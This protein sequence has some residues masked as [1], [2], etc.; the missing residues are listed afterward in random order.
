MQTKKFILNVILL[1]IMFF[2]V[3]NILIT[4]NV[5]A[6]E[7]L[8]E[9][10]TSGD[11][12][13]TDIYGSYYMGQTFTIGNTGSDAPC[14]IT[15]FKFKL[16]RVGSPTSCTLNIGAGATSLFIG[17]MYVDTTVT[18]STISTTASFYEFTFTGEWCILNSNYMY[19][20]WITVSGGDSSNYIEIYYDSASATYS[21]GKRF[22]WDGSSWLS[23]IG[24]D[25]VFYQYGK[26]PYSSSITFYDNYINCSGTHDNSYDMDTGFKIWNNITGFPINHWTT[27]IVNADLE[28]GWSTSNHDYT[29]FINT[30]GQISTI[31]KIENLL[32]TTGVHE[33]VYNSG[34][35]TFTIWANYS[36]YANI[37]TNL[38][39]TTGVHEIVCNEGIYT[40]WANYSSYANLIENILNAEGVHEIVCNNGIYTI[41]A[42]YTGEVGTGCT[43]PFYF[44]YTDEN[45]T[46]NVTVNGCED[47]DLTNSSVNST[48][49]LNLMSSLLFDDSQFITVILISLWLFM[50]DQDRKMKDKAYYGIL[51]FFVAIPLM[52]IFSVN[53]YLSSMSLGGLAFNVAIATTIFYVS[54]II[55]VLSWYKKPHNN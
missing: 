5:S 24:S 39:N 53:A 7:T 1:S 10:Y 17:S 14:N 31:N 45:I 15:S 34:T 55:F 54:F 36:S 33:Y 13:H 50:L 52:M 16:R 22:Y 44:N 27:N 9:R 23:Y 12:T 20:A 40:I 48:N 18:A 19:G 37:P 42:N 35:N 4:D 47:V 26:V 2:S 46:I 30:T 49:W 8:W 43:F 38:L 3:S 25:C 32:N 28:Y 11:D 6:S 29:V 41:W 21:G 51:Q